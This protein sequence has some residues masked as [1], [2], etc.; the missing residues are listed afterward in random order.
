MTYFLQASI[1]LI[2]ESFVVLLILFLLILINPIASILLIC[3]GA[4]LL[5]FFNKSVGKY[6]S[7]WGN[8]RQKVE[9]IRMRTLQ[10]SLGSIKEVMVFMR[11]NFFYNKFATADSLN[12]KLARK[13]STLMQIPRIWMEFFTL[14]G[15]ALMVLVLLGLGQKLEQIIP[16]FAV[17]AA[18]AFR[19]LPSFSRIMGSIQSIKYAL[20]VIK[21][22]EKDIDSK[23]I[24]MKPIEI[25][26]IN[27]KEKISLKNL[28]FNYS[29]H[30]KIIIDKVSLE[31]KKG[32]VIGLIGES[33][34]G[35]STLVDILLGLLKPTNGG[36]FIDNIQLDDLNLD[37]WKKIIGY[38]PQ[39]IFINDD[40]LINNIAFGIPEELQ[41]TE[42][43]KKAIKLANIEML[44]DG[45]N[46]LY[47]NVG[48]KGIQISGGQRQRIGIARALYHDPE[49][50]ILDEATSALDIITEKGILDSIYKMKNKKTVIIITHRL[51]TLSN[52]DVIYKIEKGKILNNH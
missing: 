10:E 48:E 22:F 37:S 20:P 50:L 40:S 51:E 30:E 6:V 43:A 21:I 5:I 34:A 12:A 4:F 25:N 33:A 16:V 35:K 41:N 7:F 47:K 9:G 36:V 49:V 46:G 2:T 18:A 28:S 15:M 52:C 24:N 29:E 13:Q 23:L 17:F 42:N 1:N 39:N 32:S 26:K 31:I 44:L 45:K 3:F 19:L 38:V 27:F 11:S 8:E 14:V